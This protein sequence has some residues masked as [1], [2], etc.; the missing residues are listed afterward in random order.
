MVTYR[1]NFV[2]GGTYFFTVNLADRRVGLLTENIGLLR[3][4]FRQVRERHPFAIDAIVVLPDHLHTIWTLPAGDADFA[5]RWRL[6]KAAFSRECAPGERISASRAM[7]GERGL[8]QRRFW[9][10][11]I[12]D[13]RDFARHVDYEHFN[14]VK[15][16]HCQRVSEWPHSSFH[17]FVRLGLLP[18]DWAGTSGCLA[19]HGADFGETQLRD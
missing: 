14:P 8:W 11:T 3:A 7:K 5:T 13:E 12:R 19:E 4:A 6:I 1:R 15:H 18:D 17:R 10:H 2:P 16:R 9:E